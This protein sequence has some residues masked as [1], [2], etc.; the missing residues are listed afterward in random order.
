MSKN[1]ISNLSFFFLPFLGL[2]SGIEQRQTTSSSISVPTFRDGYYSDIYPTGAV[3]TTAMASPKTVNSTSTA[4]SGEQTGHYGPVGVSQ[5]EA[6]I[7]SMCQPIN[8]TDQPDL[9]FPC[10]KIILFEASCLYGQNYEELLKAYVNGSPATPI[11]SG[12]DQSKCFCAET[13]P[14]PDYWQNSVQYVA[15]LIS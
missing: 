13:G 7:A 10:N 2:C 6:F 8:T 9:N 4:G 15:A 14:G 12:K 5:E 3:A 11:R 1:I